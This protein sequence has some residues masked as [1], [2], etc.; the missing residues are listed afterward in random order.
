VSPVLASRS[1]SRVAPD[2]GKNRGTTMPID[3]GAVEI[4]AMMWKPTG[5]LRWFRPPR[6]TDNDRVLQQLWERVT[7]ER[8]WRDVP[9][10]LAD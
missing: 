5:E 1:L 3:M 4:E 2:G 7:G 9:V 8:S 6:G 10:C